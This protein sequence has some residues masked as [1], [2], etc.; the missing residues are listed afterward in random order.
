MT[1]PWIPLLAVLFQAAPAAAP[2][3]RQTYDIYIR[4]ERIGTERVTEILDPS[5]NIVSSSEHDMFLTDGLSTSR[6][7]F[8]TRMTLGRGGTVPSS[9]SLHYTSGN[10][11]DY[12]EVSVQDG[13]IRRVLQR[14]GMKTEAEGKAGADTVI[15]DFNVYHQFDYVARR[16]D[17]K[18]RGRQLFQNF[19]PIVGAE[20]PLALT[21]VDDGELEHAQ[22]KIPVRNFRVELMGVLAGA[23][24]VDRDNRLVRLLVL[25][26]D[27]EVLR[28]DLSPA[29]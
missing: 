22:G 11:G 5:G 16:Y 27:L 2:A 4:G 25:D 29:P 19:V 1:G 23:F 13:R 17:F 6:V 15:F 3:Y 26:K 20:V 12:Y 21:H 8:E 10:S 7:T 28:R 9:C 18:K 24:S 14:G